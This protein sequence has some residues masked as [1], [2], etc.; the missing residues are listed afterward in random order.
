MHNSLDLQRKPSVL[1]ID[2]IGGESLAGSGFE[3]EV[4][5]RIHAELTR[6]VSSLL[7]LVF[8]ERRQTGGMDLEAVEMALRAAM[9][10]RDGDR[11]G[12]CASASARP[13]KISVSSAMTLVKAKIR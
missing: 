2:A 13:K 1:S 7:S 3:T 5:Q 11:H 12:G 10:S 6:E 4:P 8:A 9:H